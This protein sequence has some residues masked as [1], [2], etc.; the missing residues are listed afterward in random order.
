MSI[1]H[2]QLKKNVNVSRERLE[3][4][5]AQR[6]L[7][8]KRHGTQRKI[9][10]GSM[11]MWTF[12]CTVIFVIHPVWVFLIFI[13]L[14]AACFG[15]GLE[16][17]TN[18]RKGIKRAQEDAHAQLSDVVDDIQALVERETLALMNPERYAELE[19][20]KEEPVKMLD[21]PSS[22]LMAEKE[23][24]W[25]R[26]EREI[27]RK[28]KYADRERTVAKRNNL[29]GQYTAE[30]RRYMASKLAA[31]AGIPPNMLTNNERVSYTKVMPDGTVIKET[32]NLDTGE[33]EITW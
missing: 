7:W 33:V 21:R 22:T 19:R 27:E 28:A 13:F 14:M 24:R 12:S 16:G 5:H 18:A 17:M 9:F 15:L 3:R 4:S 25:R 32:I 1:T 31:E 23:Y 6:A 30:Y 29:L 26:Q 8:V 11:V 10:I 20:P 2:E